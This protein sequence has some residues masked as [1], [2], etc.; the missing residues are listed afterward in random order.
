MRNLLSILIGLGMIGYLVYVVVLVFRG[1]FGEG[2]YAWGGISAHLI[3]AGIIILLIIVG[4]FLEKDEKEKETKGDSP[5]SQSPENKPKIQSASDYNPYLDKLHFGVYQHQFKTWWYDSD[6]DT[7]DHSTLS[8]NIRFYEDGT[9]IAVRSSHIPKIEFPESF[10]MKGNYQVDKGNIT[11]SLEKVS[12]VDDSISIYISEEER[13]EMK[14]YGEIADDDSL[15]KAGNYTGRISK[16]SIIIGKFNFLKLEISKLII[17]AEESTCDKLEARVKQHPCVVDTFQDTGYWYT[18]GETGP[19]WF[20]LHIHTASEWTK[21]I[22]DLVDEE[23]KDMGR[24]ASNR[25]WG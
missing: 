20:T 18:N 25:Y 24:S 23:L 3:G 2:D 21:V 16:D 22:D 7:H 10:T 1:I 12:Q 4:Y 13:R 14:Y 9:V 8:A 17:T 15:I 6:G 5:S 19:E 11:L